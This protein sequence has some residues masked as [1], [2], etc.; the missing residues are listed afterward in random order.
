M[1]LLF[2]SISTRALCTCVANDYGALYAKSN[3]LDGRII[4][5]SVVNGKKSGL[6]VQV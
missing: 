6:L 2:L 4:N 5:A 1:P 3:I